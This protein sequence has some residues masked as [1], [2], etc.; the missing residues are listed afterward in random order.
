MTLKLKAEDMA[1]MRVMR[2]QIMAAPE[3]PEVVQTARE[4]GGYLSQQEFADTFER[5][6]DRGMV[7]G[8]ILGGAAG[9]GIAALKGLLNLSK[10]GFTSSLLLGLAGA[11]LG[12]IGG[13]LAGHG[14]A[15]RKH[16]KPGSGPEMKEYRYY[17]GTTPEDIATAVATVHLAM[18]RE[19]AKKKKK[20]LRR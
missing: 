14:L 1:A 4:N 16:R 13:M 19:A 15:V 18:A 7:A 2:A 8:G 9:L 17:A 10:G 12:S 3:F 6:Y 5:Y 20:S 11:A